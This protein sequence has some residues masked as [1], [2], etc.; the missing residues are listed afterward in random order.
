MYPNNG[1]RKNRAKFGDDVPPAPAAVPLGPQVEGMNPAPAPPSEDPVLMEQLTPPVSDVPLTDQPQMPVSDQTQITGMEDQ[2]MPVSD[3]TQIPGMDE[4]QMPVSDQTQ[5]PGMDEQQMPVSDQT[6]IPGMEDQ[7]M[8]VSPV[9]IEEQPMEP[10][11]SEVPVAPVT[12]STEV[13]VAPMETGEES[14]EIKD[15]REKM[16]D[17][18]NKKD[19]F[20]FNNNISTE[21]NKSKAYVRQGVFHFTDSMGINALRDTLTTISNF[22][23]SKGI[24]NAV[25]DKLRSIALT[26]VGILLDQ[27]QRCYNTRLEFEREGDT[28]FVHIYGTLYKRKE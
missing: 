3:Q 6:Q 19:F 26:K 27:D 11:M 22:F 8:P 14:P 4:Q 20:Y 12:S 18:N 24:E 1:T 5:I 25:Y 13:P 2:Q 10:Q 9:P 23:G 21:P 17:P 7:Q 15:F 16:A 28:I